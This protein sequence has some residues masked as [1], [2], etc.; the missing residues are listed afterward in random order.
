MLYIG[1]IEIPFPYSL[2][3]TSKIRLC[4]SSAPALVTL[5]LSYCLL[6]LSVANSWTG[7]LLRNLN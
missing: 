2:Q 5:D 6:L 1:V 3:T 4:R 7:Q